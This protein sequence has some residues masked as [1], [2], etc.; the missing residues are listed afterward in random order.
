VAEQD[1]PMLDVARGDQARSKFLRASLVKLRDTSGDEQ[2]R[3]MVDDILSGRRSLREAAS[4]EVFN[5]GIAD[6]VDEGVRQYE[7][8]SDEEKEALAAQG[9]QQFAA[10]RAQI[11]RD[12]SPGDDDDDFG[13]SGGIMRPAW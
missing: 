11:G 13:N 3:S 12:G 7:A 10:L 2:F 5:R 9:E 8:L 1:E 4:S 6:K